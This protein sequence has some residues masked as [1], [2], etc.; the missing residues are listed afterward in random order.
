MAA[1][2]SFSS[3]SAWETAAPGLRVR[4]PAQITEPRDR[5]LL[6][7]LEALVHS[8]RGDFKI[9]TPDA[10]V[11]R[12]E[13][14]PAVLDDLAQDYTVVIYDVTQGDSSIAEEKIEQMLSQLH[15]EPLV[16]ISTGPGPYRPPQSGMLDYVESYFRPAGEEGGAP[17]RFPEVTVS[18]THLGRYD[19]DPQFQKSDRDYLFAETLGASFISPTSLLGDQPLPLYGSGQEL[20]VL[21]GQQGSGKTTFLQGNPPPE[22]FLIVERKGSKQH[23]LADAQH[24]LTEG[25]SVLIDATNPGYADREEFI[26]GAV[27]LGVPVRIWWAARPGRAYNELRED[28]VPDIALRIYSSKFERPEPEPSRGITV[29]R[30]N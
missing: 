6:V 27:E 19:P 10:W 30:I 7:E 26:A 8:D 16:L 9:R 11:W 2:P 15:T 22:D 25:R 20:I 24:A 17:H 14:A 21:V 28:T 3:T 18:G 1:F 23:Y 13:T 12:T 5:L 4:H 29:E